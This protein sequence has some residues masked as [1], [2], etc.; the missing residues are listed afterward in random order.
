MAAKDVK[1]GA[2]ARERM[3]RGVDILAD[4]VKVTL[5]PKGRNVV[6]DKS[7][8]APRITKDGVT[9]AKEIELADKFE[10]MG[11]QMVR[12]VASKTND[13]AGDG[14]TTATVLAQAI[15]REGAKAVAAG[16]NPMDLKRGIDKAVSSVVA[17][18]EAKTKKITTSAEVAQVGT[19]SANGESE[20]GEMI[21]Q[22]MEKVGNE[23]V[24]TVEE[25]KSI[26]TE[27]DV[28]E[29][30]QFDRGYV[31]PYFITN[32]EKMIA[33]MDNPYILIFEKKLSQ[34]QPMLPL[35]EAVVQ[36]GR[37]LVI[38]AEDVE[39]EALATLVVNKLRGGLKIAAVKAPGFGD[40]RK[41]MLEDIA[42]LTG[43]EVI[44]E[45]LGIKL[46][47]VTLAQLGR[48]KT[49]RI[50]KE[51]T[52][53]VDGAGAKDQITG[54]CEQIKAQIE[55]TTSD[56]D[57]E[58]LQER[59]AK[60]AGGVAV[61]R[62]GGSTEVEVKERKDRVDDALHATRAAV[63]EGIVPGGGVALLRASTNLGGLKGA[64]NDE[65]V[66]I[67]I[68]RRAIQAPLKQIAENAGKDGAVI[69]GEVLR[70]DA[71]A[72]GYDAQK[73]EYKDLVVAGIIDPTKVVRTALQDAAS[74]ASL[75]ITTEAMVAERPEPKAAP[76]GG[77]PGGGMGGMDF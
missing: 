11:A 40:R 25:A 45:D 29:G 23:G 2:H 71:Y 44:S 76:A 52:T 32:A 62:V 26:Q 10:N 73:D 49:V 67:E 35:L 74:V 63:Q 15:V 68:I 6:I 38:V 37:P 47:S 14:T 51:N 39:G 70:S 27:L 5:G 50:E 22:A 56:Y 8:G 41:A 18:L 77:P 31:S 69:A 19:L 16:M 54:R 1:F 65:Q 66:G 55:E 24:I 43:G 13:T 34:L 61:I 59:L 42:I 72:H 7:F 53:I 60:L 12:E 21:A 17:E 57:R 4:A 20:I 75:L 36:S 30:M 9:V 3:L 64:N 48:A 58:K 33:E 46:E 28:V